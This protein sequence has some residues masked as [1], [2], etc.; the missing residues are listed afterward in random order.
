M[1]QEATPEEPLNDLSAFPRWWRWLFPEIELLADNPLYAAFE[2]R[3]A[4]LRGWKQVL[5]T[6]ILSSVVI[7]IC[8]AVAYLLFTGRSRAV[9]PFIGWIPWMAILA[10]QAI[11]A[12]INESLGMPSSYQQIFHRGRVMKQAFLDLWQACPSGRNIAVLISS[13]VYRNWHYHLLTWILFAV[14]PSLYLAIRCDFRPFASSCAL[15]ISLC[16]AG[17]YPLTVR[18][19]AGGHFQYFRREVTSAACKTAKK[20]GVLISSRLG[21]GFNVLLVVLGAIAAG[22]VAI[23]AGVFLWRVMGVGVI[24]DGFAAFWARTIPLPVRIALA[25]LSP[26]LLGGLLGLWFLALHRRGY[27]N[28]L[29]ALSRFEEWLD[30]ALPILAR[31]LSG[32]EVEQYELEQEVVHSWK[33]SKDGLAPQA[34]NRDKPPSDLPWRDDFTA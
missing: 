22:T 9:T 21:D 30:R 3:R 1:N 13:S 8:G 2:V 10:Y 25:V 24:I 32:D 16:V 31:T 18:S 7:A 17:G 15:A 23:L 28:H 14:G 4:Q 19:L 34:N 33:E 20:H 27:E 11:R 12:R 26:A 29:L 5:R 6:A